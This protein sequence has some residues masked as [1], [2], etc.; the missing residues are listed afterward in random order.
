M[1]IIEKGGMMDENKEYRG[2]AAI[3]ERF[4]KSQVDVHLPRPHPKQAAFIDSP[5]KRKVI[6][7]NRRAVNS[8][9]REPSIT[10]ADAFFLFKRDFHLSLL[11]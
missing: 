1:Q 6:R 11:V 8:R 2:I 3:A 5:A 10:A 4:G 9:L 7:A